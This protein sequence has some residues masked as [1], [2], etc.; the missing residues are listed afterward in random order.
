MTSLCDC[1][2]V[3]RT[4]DALLGVRF[5]QD[6]LTSDYCPLTSDFWLLASDY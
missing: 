2:I 3:Q 4:G 1:D 6:V 5:A